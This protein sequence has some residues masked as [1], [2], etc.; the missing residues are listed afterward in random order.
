MPTYEY[1]CK[2]CD[3][4]FTAMHSIWPR[5]KA[6]CTNCG[7]ENTEKQISRFNTGKEDSGEHTGFC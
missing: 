2:Q 6:K 5:K 1:K 4:K 7:S 3:S